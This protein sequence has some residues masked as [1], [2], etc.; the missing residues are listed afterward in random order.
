[1]TSVLVDMSATLIHHGHIRLLNYAASLGTVTVALTTD[2]EITIN[3]GYKPELS[4]SHRRE[5]LLALSS[6]SHVI[7]SPWL[8]TYEF[9]MSTGCDLLVHGDD[10]SN[11]IPSDKLVLVPRTAGISSS[12]LRRRVLDVI[13]SKAHLNDY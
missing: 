7:E 11:L 4:Y 6:V 10:N 9:F 2:E 13:A 8:L 1:M 12:I 5:V 3:K